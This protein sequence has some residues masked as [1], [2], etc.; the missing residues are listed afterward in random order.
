MMTVSLLRPLVALIISCGLL[1]CV[2][3]AADEDAKAKD[4][5]SK[6]SELFENE[7]FEAAAI[8]FKIAYKYKPSW[9]LLYNIGQCE[10]GAKRYGIALEA[11]EQY[12][13]ESGD[14]IS[15]ERR[16][17]VRKE[18]AR[19]RDMVGM[20]MVKG[21]AGSE[22]FIDGVKRGTL[23]L[24]GAVPVTASKDHLVSGV[25]SGKKLSS[26]TVK[27]MTGQNM[28]IILVA[29]AE[30]AVVPPAPEDLA[31]EADQNPEEPA[32]SAQTVTGEDKPEEPSAREAPDPAKDATTAPEAAPAKDVHRG[33]PLM[34]TG[35]ALLAGGGAVL[36][37]SLVTGL[38]AMKKNGEIED[39]CME[40]SGVDCALDI[41]MRDTVDQRDALGLT[42]TILWI[43]GGAL[44]AAGAVLLIVG[45]K[46][47][48][49]MAAGPGFVPS[50][51]AD[52][53]GGALEWRF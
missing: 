49:T 43:G 33:R 5:F 20:L 19:L 48:E 42:T 2:C 23:P 29:T 47:G 6:G 8:Q 9:K 38:L 25:L 4:A 22:L 28:E 17:E 52:G 18:T 10:V 40:R 45:K 44:A 1:C 41:S 7:Q 31:I 11:F 46:K 16:D 50:I 3:A 32:D 27:V 51:A 21:P 35:I 14:E 36:A 39:A 34:I 26:A 15:L 37:G 13:V 12:L 24:S 30:D 53:F